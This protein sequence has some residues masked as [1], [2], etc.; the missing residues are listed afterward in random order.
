MFVLKNSGHFAL[1]HPDL[2]SHYPWAKTGKQVDKEK[3]I[4]GVQAQAVWW[5]AERLKKI[6]AAK[7]DSMEVNPFMA[8]LVAALHN[9]GDFGE[10]AEFLIGGHFAIGHA[11]GFGKLVDEKILPNVFG[12]QKLGKAVRES[13]P[14]LKHT[15]FDN[16][17]H[18][19]TKNGKQIFL[20]QKASRW[21]IQLGQ[22]VEL[23]RSFQ[24]LLELRQQKKID[25]EK[26]IVATFYGKKEGL[27]DKY[28]I[29]RG[30]TTGASHDV[31]DISAHVEILAGKE[32]W[33]WIGDD[34]DTQKWVMEG[35]LR[36]L[37]QKKG[38]LEQA[39]ELLAKFKESFAEQYKDAIVDGKVDWQLFLSLINGQ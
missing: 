37:N 19:V 2:A 29:V 13:V 18:I 3:V 25:F 11:T 26:I 20:S 9:Q 33:S 36:A 1:C 7:H 32:F 39:A 5:L 8:P 4:T 17:D 22:A 14:I 15:A 21:T 6:Q 12:T 10:I 34:D 24:V 27:S 28:R 31:T 23:N 35:I 16:V 30:I 38:E